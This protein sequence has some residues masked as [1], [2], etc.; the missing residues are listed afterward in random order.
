MTNCQ[1]I[2]SAPR[3]GSVMRCDNCAWG[4][5]FKPRPDEVAR[6]GENVMGCTRLNWEG[7][8]QRDDKCEAFRPAPAPQE[9]TH[10]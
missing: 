1:P 3:D 9:P 6:Y 2:D 8:T 10:D 7:Y 5:L 4:R